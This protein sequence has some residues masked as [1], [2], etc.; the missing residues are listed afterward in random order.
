MQ[1]RSTRPHHGIE[2]QALRQMFH[3]RK[4]VF[5][6][7]LGWDI[8]VID[9][10][11]DIDQF[12]TPDATYIIITDELGRHRASA[13]LLHTDLPHILGDLFPCLCDG[14]VPRS[15]KLREITRFCIEPELPARERRLA[16]NQLVSA[17]ADHAL[18]CDLSGYSAVASRTWY[19]QI[20]KFGWRCSRLG[21]PCEINGEELV[22]LHIGIDAQTPADLA[23][24]G[25]YTP[26]AFRA[27]ATELEHAQ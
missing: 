9:G 21:P 7:V 1:Y 25:I 11:Y 27:T 16:R 14:P 26:A 6:D 18:D 2:D 23:S 17:L 10:I 20:A 8:P 3:A 22:G 15:P 12:D 24:R 19:G 5:V 4:R 13:R